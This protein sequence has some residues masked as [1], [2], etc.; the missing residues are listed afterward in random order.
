MKT[1][2]KKYPVAKNQTA[3]SMGSGDLEV[4]ATPALV[5]M[6]ENCAKCLVA[7]ELSAG[8]TTVGFK[9]DLKHLAPSAMGAEIRIEAE[10]TDVDDQKLSFAIEAYDQAALIGMASHQRVIVETATFLKKLK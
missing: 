10:I 1:L 2:T 3:R 6:M 9:M 8:Q 7:E 5:A 4:L